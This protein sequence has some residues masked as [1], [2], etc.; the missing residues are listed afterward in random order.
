MD[1]VFSVEEIP[2]HFWSSSAAGDGDDD[3]NKSPGSEMNRSASEWAFQRLLREEVDKKGEDNEEEEAKE[4][5]CFENNKH[6]NIPA[7]VEDYQ[8]FLKKKLNLACAA[9]AMSMASFAKPQDSAA[10]AD[11][12]SQ[13]SNTPQLGSKTVSRGAGDKDDNAVAEVPSFPSGQKKLRAQVRPSTS[14]GSSKEQ[15]DEDEVEGENETM[16]NMDPA[17][18]KRVRRMLSNRESARRSRRRKQA[19]LTELESQ[20]SQLRVENTNLLKSL[21]DIS[22]RYNE[23]AV[24]NRILKADV[25]T[26]KAKVKMAEE[27]VKRTTGLN[28]VFHALPEIPSMPSFDGYP[29]DTSTD[30][31]VYE[32]DGPKHTLYQAAANES[33]S[34]HDLRINNA[35]ADI[36][37]VENIQSASEGSAVTGNKI[38]RTA[39]LQ[40]VASLEHLQKRIRGGVSLNGKQ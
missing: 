36:S 15:S 31:A 13:A 38:G 29:S 16:E 18:V 17:D 26:L 10:R 24:N 23:A 9:V 33:I 14:T 11:S 37:S 7:D 5:G 32:E 19:H 28:P 20:V 35:L 6:D 27:A 12:G 39:S 25:E 4:N 34:T 21:T 3:K 1:R 22:Q 40:R 30:A 8:A 2:D